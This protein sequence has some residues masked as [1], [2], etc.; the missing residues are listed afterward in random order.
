MVV[1]ALGVLNVIIS[2]SFRPFSLQFDS[3]IK[4][5]QIY[6]GQVSPLV[7]DPYITRNPNLADLLTGPIIDPR[8]P[9]LGDKYAKVNLVLFSDY[10][11]DYCAVQEQ[12]IKKLFEN[13]KHYIKVI[14]KDYP[15][16]NEDSLSFQAARAGQC[17]ARQEKFWPYHD[18]LFEYNDELGEEKYLEIAKKL[19]LNQ[20]DFK[21]CLS[22]KEVDEKIYSNIEEANMLEITGIP[23]LYVGTQQVM[24]EIKYS[25]LERLVKL[26][27]ERK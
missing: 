14:W 26:E 16:S 24:G 7:S 3:D 10:T 6:D 20:R 23:F 18:F 2:G 19:D 12:A 25:E 5:N 22:D 9:W 17:A 21:K 13:Y 8:D 4:D 11:C 27:L 15:E 1:F